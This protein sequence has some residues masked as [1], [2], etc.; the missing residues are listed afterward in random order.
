MNFILDLVRL[1]ALGVPLRVGLSALA[2]YLP[3]GTNKRAQTK[4]QSLTQ[5]YFQKSELK[6]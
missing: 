2:F 5:F 6:F 3:C 1:E 4:P